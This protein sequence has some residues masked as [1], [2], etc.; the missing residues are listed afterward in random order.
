M[1]SKKKASKIVIIFILF[2]FLV[3][4]WLSAVVPYIGKTTPNGTWDIAS[5]TTDTEVITW[6]A[7]D[8]GTI[9]LPKM[10]KEEASKKLQQL[11][12]VVSVLKN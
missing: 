4:T 11:L 6:T 9:E 8:T 1:I 7:S 10:T 2:V 12:S 5:W 3:I